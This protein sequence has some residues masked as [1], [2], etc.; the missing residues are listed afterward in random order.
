MKNNHLKALLIT[1]L[2]VLLLSLESLFI[3]LTAI[4]ALTFSF[5]IAIFMLISSNSILLVSE[6]STFISNYKTNL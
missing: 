6:K 5:Y 4:S 2:G 1:T 3:K